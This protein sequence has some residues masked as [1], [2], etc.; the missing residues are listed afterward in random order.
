MEADLA[1]P[2]PQVDGLGKTTDEEILYTFVSDY[3]STETVVQMLSSSLP[4]AG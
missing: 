4:G 2:I 1:S 3:A